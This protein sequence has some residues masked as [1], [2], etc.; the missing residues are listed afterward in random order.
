[1]RVKQD[2][3][4]NS[5]RLDYIPN[6]NTFGLGKMSG[7]TL[8]GSARHKRLWVWQDARLNSLGLSYV[9]DLVA[10]GPRGM[11]DLISLGYYLLI[12]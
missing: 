6:P 3:K 12:P 9:L 11:L 1:L 10:F 7:L 2:A 5:S 8:L 4:P